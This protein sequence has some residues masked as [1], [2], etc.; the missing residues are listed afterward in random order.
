M[1]AWIALH[2]LVELRLCPHGLR[3]TALRVSVH[4]PHARVVLKLCQRSYRRSSPSLSQPRK[5]WTSCVDQ[6]R[7]LRSP[8]AWVLYLRRTRLCS[9]CGRFCS[10]DA[11][12]LA[13]SASRKFIVCVDPFFALNVILSPRS[14]NFVPLAAR[15]NVFLSPPLCGSVGEHLH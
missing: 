3:C 5:K 15:W 8:Y 14:C 4:W 10:T 13:M 11:K 12:A 2:S 9:F 6:S 7:R 1:S